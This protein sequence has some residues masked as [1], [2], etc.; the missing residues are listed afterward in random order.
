[1]DV[2]GCGAARLR[3]QG[4]LYW[5]GPPAPRCL[6]TGLRSGPRCSKVLFVEPFHSGLLRPVRYLPGGSFLFRGL[7]LQLAHGVS[8]AN[9]YEQPG[10]ESALRCL[11][12]IVH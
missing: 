8:H 5:G 9:K 7:F 1:M 3:G 10:N 11:N 2:V 12:G 4:P 6:T